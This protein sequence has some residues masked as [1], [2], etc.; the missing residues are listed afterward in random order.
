MK[1]KFCRHIYE[2][3]S[4]VLLTTEHYYNTNYP[5]ASYELKKYVT[6][7]VCIKCNKLKYSKWQAKSPLIKLF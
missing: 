4:V 5:L 1:L 6:K 2:D 3:K 7:A